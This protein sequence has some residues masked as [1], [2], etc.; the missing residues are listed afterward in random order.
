M[1]LRKG[2]ERNN[3]EDGTHNSNCISRHY[4]GRLKPGVSMVQMNAPRNEEAE[5]LLTSDAQGD[6]VREEFHKT[7]PLSHT[8]RVSLENLNGSVRISVWDRNDIQV[9][10]I[11]HAYKAERLNEATIEVNSNPEAIRIKTNY[12]DDDQSFNEGHGDQNDPAV[13]DYTITIPRQARLESINLVNGSLDIDGAEGNVK[14][15]SV[16]GRVTARGLMGEAKLSHCE[17]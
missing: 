13:V 10:A 12:P 6:E 2:R 7:Y 15:S 3:V 5:N 4:P 17:W 8:G 11:K 14:A 1:F 9:D 16:N